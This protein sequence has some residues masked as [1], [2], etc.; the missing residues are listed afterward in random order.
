[1]SEPVVGKK[2]S[3]DLKKAKTFLQKE[4]GFPAISLYD[5]MAEIVTKVLDEQIEDSVNSLEQISLE[6]KRKRFYQT[7]TNALFEDF[8][9]CPAAEEAKTTEHLFVPADNLEEENIEEQEE[10]GTLP[11]NVMENLHFFEQAGLGLP[12]LEAFQMYLAIKMLMAE[13]H[14]QHVRFWGKILG[15]KNNYYVVEAEFQEGE[16]PEE[17]EEVPPDEEAGEPPT[18]EHLDELGEEEEAPEPPDP[19]PKFVPP[20]RP[21]V[22]PYGTGANKKVYFVTN[23]PGSKWIR[24]PN[25][26]PTEIFVARRIKKMFTGELD[27]PMLTYPPFPGTEKNYLRA[28]IARITA[29]THISPVGFY[30]FDEEEEADLGDEESPQSC[31]E[32]PEFDPIPVRELVAPDLAQWCHHT[33]HILP[34]G[35]CQWWNPSSRGDDEEEAEEE[36]EEEAHQ[37]PEVGP[38]LLTP[39]SEDATMD[40]MPAWVVR[41]S[42]NLSS[43]HSLAVIRSTLWPG[44]VAFSDGKRFDN[45]YIG[46]GHKFSSANYGPEAPPGRDL[47]FPPSQDIKH[48]LD[49]TPEEE[50]EFLAAQQGEEEE[51]E[52]ED[53]EEEEEEED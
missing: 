12:R 10:L 33:L 41:M 30:Q 46:N 42:S 14:L 18:E 31:M 39:L 15:L 36:E 47:C 26:T 8:P 1:M 22:E 24:L 17:E 5:H 51:E 35:R 44:S 20:P 53:E 19:R 50:A 49:P 9:A 6:L 34:Q 4:D 27:N 48:A 16:E 7:D 37:E 40:G 32:N 13:S 52:G 45:F 29:G 38:P 43:V 23:G 3:R 28:Q 21:P 2:F 25:V 11:P